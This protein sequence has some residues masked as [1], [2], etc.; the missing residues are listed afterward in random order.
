M[1]RLSMRFDLR[2][3][4]F[5]KTTFSEQHRAMLE[6]ATWADRVGVEAICLSEHH[7]D[8]AGFSS[9][10]ITLA[11]AVLAR[12]G[13]LKVSIA[14][15]LVPFHDP[16]RLAEQLAT[17]DCLA[18]GRLSVVLGAG[19][20]RAEFAMAGID[21]RERGPLLEECVAVLRRAWTGEPFEW[22]GR[23][24]LATPPPATPGGP[25]LFVGG[26][27]IAGA[28]RAARLRC[29]F[30]PAVARLDVIGAYFDECE[31]L[32]FAGA[33]VF[34]SR[35][36]DEFRERHPPAAPVAPG[37][38]MVTR[39]PE[40]T[41]ARIAPHAEYDARTYV[42]W[43]EDGVVSDWAVPGAETWK[44]LRDS[45]RYAVVTPQQ[46]L[47]LAARDGHLMLHPLMGGIGPALAWE[48]LRL[49][50]GEVLPEMDPGAAAPQAASK[51]D[52]LLPT[53]VA[54]G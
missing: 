2:V 44:D 23:E 54:S 4:P 28:R 27:T 13:R 37:F 12:T 36:L 34:G 3:P 24:V 45:G 51:I 17:V 8:P 30:S 26:K 49:F 21:R 18:P 42:A 14:A 6:M 20:R 40:A 39:D 5:A 32:G 41:W 35:S 22:R 33:D 52:R 1:P 16:V 31:R 47:A 53:G 15:A 10:P 46:C 7:G 29:A 19:Y 11:A 50:E 9:A 48:G 25:A 38:V 43:Q